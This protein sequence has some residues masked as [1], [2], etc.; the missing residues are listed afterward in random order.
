[1]EDPAANKASWRAEMMPLFNF[2]IIIGLFLIGVFFY[3][4]ATAVKMDQ[5]V[6]ALQCGAQNVVFGV[7]AG[8]TCWAIANDRG[9]TVDALLKENANLNCDKL[10]VGQSICVPAA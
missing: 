7:R 8:D 6:K 4:R 10:I 1:M 3:L 5:D 9:L 2:F